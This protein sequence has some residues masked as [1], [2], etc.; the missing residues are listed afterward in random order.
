MESPDLHRDSESPSSTSSEELVSK[1]THDT[2]HV[3]RPMNAF[4]VW[5]RE[6]RRM[7]AQENPKM[8]NSEIS[9]VSF[10]VQTVETAATT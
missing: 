2:G 4:M 1:P 6:Q 7:I 3:K 8:H 5:S 9:K 10:F